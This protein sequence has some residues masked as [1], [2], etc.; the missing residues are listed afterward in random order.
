M[1]RP[2]FETAAPLVVVI[3]FIMTATAGCNQVAQSES[4]ASGAQAQP[5]SAQ[6]VADHIAGTGRGMTALREASDSGKYL[7]A[8]FFKTEDEQTLAMRKVYDGA[9]EKVADRARRVAVNIT[10]ASEK[11]VVAKFDL[12]R[13]PMPLVLSIAPN[14][15][16]TGGFPTKFG[17][18]QLV[19]AFATP[20]TEEVMK[21]L[22]DGKLVFVCI[23]NA[24]TKCNAD[25]MQGV[26]DF[27]ADSRFAAATEI[28]TIDPG[29]A[30]EIGFLTDLKVSPDTS[31]AATVFVVPPG[32]AIAKFEGATSKDALVELISKAGSACGP[33]GCGPGGCCPAK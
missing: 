21:S 29:D 17:V 9:M 5:Q 26:R 22:Q 2:H 24:K 32:K 7:F 6:P 16:I 31:E 33:G 30:K 3:A 27:K 4:T 10:D 18:Q 25:A 15:A 28:V 12:E 11:D 23:Q 13:A 1:V 14:G 20:A 8:F 19:D